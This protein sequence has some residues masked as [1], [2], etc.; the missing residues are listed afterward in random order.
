MEIPHTIKSYASCLISF[1][2]FIDGVDYDISSSFSWEQLLAITADQVAAYLDMRAYSTPTPGPDDHLL[3]EGQTPSI[4]KRK[5]SPIF[6]LITPCNGMT[7]TKEAA[8]PVLLPSMML[9]LR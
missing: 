5:K 1:V 9:L 8:P 6:C 3:M 4:F 7:S 2:F